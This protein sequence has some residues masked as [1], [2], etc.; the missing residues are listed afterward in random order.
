MDE[1]LKQIENI[2]RN[3]EERIQELN[4]EIIAQA[5]SVSDVVD[6]LEDYV[7][8]CHKEG[9]FLNYKKYLELVE[10][11]QNVY[12][13][14][15]NSLIGVLPEFVRDST[16][17]LQ[18]AFN[19]G[20][21]QGEVKHQEEKNILN[22]RLKATI[23]ENASIRDDLSKCYEYY[24]EE[25]EQEIERIKKQP[26]PAQTI[27]QEEAKPQPV[28]IGK[29]IELSKPKI[30]EIIMLYVK[31]LSISAISKET[32]HSREK[33][34]AVIYNKY[35]HPASKKKILSVINR[36]LKENQNPKTIEKLKEL[37]NKYS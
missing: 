10:A 1:I 8:I 12:N 9:L 5:Q 36:L 25:L 35:K 16:E 37:K 22:E 34:R 2:K 21:K 17:K 27:A 7:P 23:K 4:I 14:A 3:T 28:A 30:K 20:L 6:S 29:A 24:I 13:S 18:H 11:Q 33:V 19:E 15:I 26:P 31:G 32:K